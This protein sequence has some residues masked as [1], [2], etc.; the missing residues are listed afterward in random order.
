MTFM[1][2][3]IVW[4][5]FCQG[6]IKGLTKPFLSHEPRFQSPSGTGAFFYYAA[7]S[8]FFIPDFMRTFLTRASNHR[9]QSITEFVNLRDKLPKNIEQ[10]LKAVSAQND[11]DK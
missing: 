7:F 9:N 10:V 4:R 2:S 6:E 5:T 3:D 8:S 11:M 1:H